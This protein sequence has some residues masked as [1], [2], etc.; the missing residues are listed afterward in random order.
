MLTCYD[1]QT[2]GHLAVRLADPR[3]V[4]DSRHC[5]PSR[6]EPRAFSGWFLIFLH[7]E[8][9]RKYKDFKGQTRL[10]Y[11]KSWT[12]DGFSP[13]IAAT[14]KSHEFAHAETRWSNLSRT[15]P[16]LPPAPPRCRR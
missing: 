14:R 3:D 4:L 15:Q 10:E 8:F 12:T 11:E 13:T 2:I 1:F 7:P 9:I 6:A 5:V 16:C